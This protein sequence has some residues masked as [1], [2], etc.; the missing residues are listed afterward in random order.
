MRQYWFLQYILLVISVI[1]KKKTAGKIEII[2]LKI[3]KR[4]ATGSSGRVEVKIS[5]SAKRDFSLPKVHKHSFEVSIMRHTIYQYQYY[6]IINTVVR[7]RCGGFF[8]YTFVDI[9]LRKKGT[10][11][12][13]EGL[14]FILRSKVIHS[15][16]LKVKKVN[17]YKN[18]DF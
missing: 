2:R 9:K 8:L 14:S 5:F 16:P 7:Y 4:R 3:R 18:F 17:R 12:Y 11:R 15:L 13:Y 6:L 10:S 1:I